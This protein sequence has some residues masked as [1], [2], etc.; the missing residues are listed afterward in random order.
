MVGVEH[1]FVDPTHLR[2]GDNLTRVVERGGDDRLDRAVL[3]GGADRDQRV[4]GTQQHGEALA[5]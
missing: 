5:I 1:A 3:V 4:T 2:P